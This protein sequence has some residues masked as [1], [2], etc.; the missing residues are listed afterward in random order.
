[1]SFEEPVLFELSNERMRKYLVAKLSVSKRMM[2]MFIYED[3]IFSTILEAIPKLPLKRK[4]VTAR[5]VAKLLQQIDPV[6]YGNY[7][8]V[9]PYEVKMK[10]FSVT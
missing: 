4:C 10:S 5:E 1:M 2:D 7:N 3:S 9:N 8:E 6:D